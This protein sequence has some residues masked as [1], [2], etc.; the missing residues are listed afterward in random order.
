MQLK[1]TL[2][3]LLLLLLTSLAW[4]QATISG[5]IVDEENEKVSFATVLL[6]SA[7]DSTLVKGQIS[8]VDG[9]YN[10]PQIKEG[11]YF[12]EATF[13][14]FERLIS[15]PFYFNGSQDEVLPVLTMSTSPGFT[16]EFS[17]S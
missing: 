9:K 1:I 11:N 17:F 13:V 7:T 4:S 14:G 5:N 8:D 2:T 15:A 16:S 12:I 10:F 6:N 3:T